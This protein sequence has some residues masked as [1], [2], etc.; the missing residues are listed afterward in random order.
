M[1]PGLGGA[2]LRCRGAARGEAAEEGPGAAGGDGGDRDTRA[3][4]LQPGERLLC[5]T[6]EIFLLEK[7]VKNEL[8]T[9][10]LIE[11]TVLQ[12]HRSLGCAGNSESSQLRVAPLPFRNSSQTSAVTPIF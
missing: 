3:G 10:P 5:L 1:S 4:R 7:I 9:S 11:E 8:K 12:G 6:L 2:A